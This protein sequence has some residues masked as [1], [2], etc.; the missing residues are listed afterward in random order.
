LEI[1]LAGSRLR[2]FIGIVSAALF[3]LGF[4][5]MA[6][7]E[8]AQEKGMLPT[9]PLTPYIHYISGIEPHRRALVVPGLDS[10]KELMQIFCAA[11]ADDGFEVYSIDLPGHGDSPV[12]FNAVL[13][14]S[15]LEQAVSSLNPDIA[16]GHSMGAALLIDLAH[17]VKFRSLV[18]ISPV[19]TQVNGLEFEHTLV[20]T[21]RWDIPAVNAFVPQ[22]QGIDLRKFEWGMH[23]SA[24]YYPGQI[25]EIVRW[26]G[27][28]PDR[29]RTVERF[30]WLGCMFA[31]AIVLAIVLL[32]RRPSAPG[33]A[34]AFS[35]TEVLLGFVFAGGISLVVQRF[36]VVLRWVRLYAT[37]YMVSFLFVAGLVL[38]TSLAMRKESIATRTKVSGGFNVFAK[39][40]GAAAYVI[41]TFGLLVGSHLIHMTLSDGR[42]WR[43]MVIAAASFP[44][45]LFDE[46]AVRQPGKGWQNA[47]VAIVSRGLLS[48]W[49]A[50]G[51]LMF[52]RE[53]A[54]LV[55]LLGLMILFWVTLWFFT[56]LVR[57]NVQNPAAAALF[58]ALVQGWMFAAWFV[59]V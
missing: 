27:G 49:M 14:R 26:L 44:L 2:L 5:G 39:A 8:P 13:A 55:L 22:L 32:P 16:V 58:A 11:L 48:A 35:Q 7:L 36:V 33:V 9:E 24:P 18:L 10:N 34:A 43:F 47:A 59:T 3:L 40:V 54:F 30:V 53:S 23:S 57:R 28:H 46:I 17:D 38:L 52:N 20:T 42:W 12:G 45:F 19:P 21:E 41:I 51:V 31:A 6:A 1:S 25:R 15:T 29:L 4:E 37:D 56:G 50:T